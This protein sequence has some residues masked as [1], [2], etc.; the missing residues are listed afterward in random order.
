MDLSFPPGCSV[1]DGIP[2]DTYLGEY[3]KLRLPGIDWLVEF[4]LEKGR[5]CLVFKKDLRQ[6]Y[7]HFPIDPKD[8]H[9]LG[10][11]YQGKFY[12]DTR[13][14]FGLRSLAMICQRTTKAVVHIFTEQGF[15]ADVYLDDFC[16]AEY[17]SL[18]TSAFSQLSQLFHQLGLDSAPDK[19]SPPSTSMICLRILVDTVAFTLEVPAT[20]L[21][22]LQAKLRTWQ[23]AS[24]F[25]KKQL[26]SLLRKLSFVT[27]CVKPGR[28]FMP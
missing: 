23:A 11:R 21:T 22:D 13:C 5:H 1:N 12:F 18:A 24:F 8:Y 9:L 10:F 4:I 28:I 16:G 17:P 6:A 15:L 25:T 26:Q 7:R 3:Y 19:D 20:R 2:Q 14:R 27:A